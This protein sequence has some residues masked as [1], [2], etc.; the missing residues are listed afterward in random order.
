MKSRKDVV[1]TKQ[2]GQVSGF[3]VSMEDTLGKVKRSKV[4]AA[5]SA[6]KGN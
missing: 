5:M 4:N 1:D 2:P 3:F 6:I